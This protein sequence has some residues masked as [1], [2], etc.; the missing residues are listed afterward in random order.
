MALFEGC[1]EIVHV[2]GILAELLP[3]GHLPRPPTNL[4]GDNAGALAL[5]Q[6]PV[7]TNRNKHF[8]TKLHFTRLLAQAAV[9]RLRKAP[10]AAMWADSLTKALPYV[11]FLEHRHALHGRGRL[12]RPATDLVIHLPPL[13]DFDPATDCAAAF[14]DLQDGEPAA[15]VELPKERA[16]VR[17]LP[18]QPSPRGGV[19]G[20][21][22]TPARTG[23]RWL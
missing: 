13:P 2:R 22:L 3:P 5:D 19:L 7:Q 12:T 4:F 9:V 14:A 20:L 6:N 17:P 16:H 15:P 8:P 1:R 10:S 23:G 21:D 11:T 18:Q